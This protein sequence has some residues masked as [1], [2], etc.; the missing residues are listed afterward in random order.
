MHLYNHVVTIIY[1]IPK[2]WKQHMYPSIDKCAN[3]VEHIDSV[4]SSLKKEGEFDKCHNLEDIVIY[5]TTY[6]SLNLSYSTNAESSQIYR[7]RVKLWL[8]K[9]KEGNRVCVL[10]IEC[11]IGT[12]NKVKRLFFKCEFTELINA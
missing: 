7:N 11:Q 12:L 2:R 8:L 9:N 5:Q 10:D 3:N 1:T 6:K 4:I